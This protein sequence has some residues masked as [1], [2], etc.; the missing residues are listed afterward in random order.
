M[1]TDQ[2]KFSFSLRTCTSSHVLKNKKLNSNQMQAFRCT[3]VKLYINTTYV[4]ELEALFSEHLFLHS[5]FKHIF[6]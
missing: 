6:V 4:S 5:T 1:I 2:I 3:N